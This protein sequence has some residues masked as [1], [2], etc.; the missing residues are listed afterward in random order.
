MAAGVFKF[1]SPRARPQ[2]IDIQAAALWGVAAVT[3]ALW[4]VQPFDWLKKTFLEKPAPEE[5]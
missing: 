2:P 5:K 4:I 1:L 3:T